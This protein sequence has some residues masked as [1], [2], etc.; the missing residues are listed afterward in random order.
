LILWKCGVRKRRR[1]SGGKCPPPDSDPFNDAEFGQNLASSSSQ[2]AAT[3]NRRFE[4]DKSG[5]LFIRTHNEPL[6][7]IAMCVHD[8]DCSS[9]K[10][11]G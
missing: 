5:Q 11:D 9:L 6:S 8:P 4:F 10:I 2:F 1:T 7:V 3:P